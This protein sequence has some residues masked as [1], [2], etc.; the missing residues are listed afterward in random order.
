[1]GLARGVEGPVGEPE[2][3]GDSPRY[4]YRLVDVRPHLRDT[5]DDESYLE[6]VDT[7]DPDKQRVPD[8]GGIVQYLNEMGDH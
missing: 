7:A 3:H 6:I 1:M 4:E 5:P 2:T 8:E